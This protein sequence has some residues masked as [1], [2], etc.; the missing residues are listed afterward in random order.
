M[1][2]NVAIVIPALD[3][4]QYYPEG[5]LV[6]FGDT[7]L[8]EWKISQVL[9]VVENEN[10]YI[11][12]PSEKII[13]LAGEYGIQTIKRGDE[14]DLSDW[15]PKCIEPISKKNILWAHVTSP[16]LSA[17]DYT[18]MLKKFFSLDRSHDSLIAVS[19]E[20]EYI[21][22]Q[23]KPLNFDIN[24]YKSRAS[25]KPVYRITNG[26]YISQKETYHQNRK[27]FGQSPFYF[28]VDKLTALEIK[29]IDHY[30]MASSLLSLYFKVKEI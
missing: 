16:F 1:H 23:N 13:A 22:F 15:I 4:N 30:Q 6:K 27:Y 28:E 24:D 3:K 7:T 20:Q 12:T 8:L 2:T 17:S 18:A 5:D 11:A 14:S 10:I 26:C 21:C 29:D 19:K 9:G 25:L